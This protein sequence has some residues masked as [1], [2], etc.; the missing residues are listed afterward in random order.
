M[1][2]EDNV[3]T[4]AFQAEISQLMSLIINTFYSNKSIFLRELISNS[5]DALDKIRYD[6]LTNENQVIDDNWGRKLNLQFFEYLRSVV[7]IKESPYFWKQFG[8]YPPSR[9]LLYKKARCVYFEH[10]LSGELAKDGCIIPINS[11]VVRFLNLLVRDFIASFIKKII[12]RIM[13]K[14]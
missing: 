14:K 3:E 7:I 12:A 2:A 9:T 8:I 11:G 1:S 4:F 6:G 13:L 10:R 5:S